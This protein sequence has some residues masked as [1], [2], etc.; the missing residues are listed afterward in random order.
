MAIFL[1]RGNKLR[2]G[3]SLVTYKNENS[4]YG[5]WRQTILKN[6]HPCIKNFLKTAIEYH[7]FQ[8]LI[9][10]KKSGLFTGTHFF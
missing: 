9:L 4:V 7:W 8:H 3:N 2:K 6:I 1:E 10:E 5:S